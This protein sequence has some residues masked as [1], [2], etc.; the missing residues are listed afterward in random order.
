MRAQL[1]TQGAATAR[2]Y[3]R[4]Y[5]AVTASAQKWVRPAAAGL[6]GTQAVATTTALLGGLALVLTGHGLVLALGAGAVLS[7]V[8]AYQMPTLT[9]VLLL[10]S[11]IGPALFEMTPQLR[12]G[13]FTVARIPGPALVML[14]MAAA[15]TVRLAVD[16]SGSRAVRRVNGFGVA[17]I[18]AG[19]LVVWLGLEVARNLGSHHL[20]SVREFADENLVL[21]VPLYLATFLRSEHSTLRAFK[22]VAVIALVA[23]IV[24]IPVVGSMKGW[25]L[26]SSDRF[27]PAEV[28]LGL[29]FGIVSLLLLKR[30]GQL[31]VAWWVLCLG[32]FVA[33]VLIVVDSHRS[34]WLSC[35]TALLVL[36]LLGEIRLQRFWHWGFAALGFAAAAMLTLSAAGL[37]V[38]RYVATRASAFVS[39]SSD[40][41]SDWRF[42][43]WRQALPIARTHLLGGQGFGGY[44][45][46]AT[47]AGS[48]IDVAPHDMYIQL[49]LKTGVIGVALA[50]LL[51]A[52]TLAGLVDGWR[53]VRSRCA[54]ELMPVIAVGVAAVAITY[55]W[56]IVYQPAV[57]CFVFA[58]LGVAAA[59]RVL[60]QRRER[61]GPS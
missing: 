43:I 34:V 12:Q 24:L 52:T 53:T 3:A 9:L 19:A 31:H 15:L 22:V 29:L 35:A 36:V 21:V 13:T 39:P 14:P 23:P 58:G 55:V 30:H 18:V 10:V 5:G 60:S 50:L 6:N 33:T 4:G 11:W 8:V 1:D 54:Q 46:W 20:S 7:V 17:R 2:S 28:H 26:G 61:Q 42:S 48:S 38:P 57:Y 59:L 16:L 47:A 49:L 27:Y 56:G 44:F 51:G 32:T 45:A 25:G 37:D 41:T 40:P